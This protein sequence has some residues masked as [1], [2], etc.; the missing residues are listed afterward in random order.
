MS[1]PIKKIGDYLIESSIETTA[2]SSERRIRVRLN[3]EGVEKRPLVAETE[4][5]TRY[6][7]RSA[8]QFIYGKQNLHKGAFGVVP[9]E[10]DSFESSSDL[11]AF[12]VA[13]GLRAEWLVYFLKQGNFYKSLASI[14]RG[15]ATK[16]IQPEAFFG[17]ELPVP[18]KELQDELIK[19]MDKCVHEN[20]K[21]QHEITHQETLLTK[22]RQAI[23]QE[24]IQG[25]LTADWRAANPNTEP[26]SELL[27]RIQTEKAKLIADKK[28][29]KEKPLPPIK[30]EE[31][32]F[33][34][35]EGWEWCR[36]GQSGI[37]Q[38]GKSKHRPRNDQRLFEDGDIPFVQTGNVARSK[39]NG[40]KIDTCTGYYNQFG[41]AQ[42]RLWPSG[43]MCITIAAN[44]AETGFLQF[45]ACFPDSVVAFVSATEGRT[46]EFARLFIELTRTSI[47]R[48]APAT[49]QK[50]INLEILSELMFPLPPLAEQAAIVERVD[51][52][53]ETCRELETEIENSRTHADQLLQAVLKEAFSPAA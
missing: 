17:V 52:L 11:P 49:A 39:Q 36:M 40:F 46:S 42:S 53:M 9:S 37:F 35:P 26:A 8:G 16:R 28:L 7:R 27:K 20:S 5:A 33:E 15:A 47:E 3:A 12:V 10:L 2:P 24:A 50:N 31:I 30:P 29:K 13:E 21:L 18:S 32:P 14:A 22:L 4:G 45:P 25:K 19:Q 43:T 34:I 41:L 44:I 48:F 38:R 51:A 6:Y 1:W 23:L